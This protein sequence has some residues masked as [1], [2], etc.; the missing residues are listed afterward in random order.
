MIEIVLDENADNT[1]LNA[2]RPVYTINDTTEKTWEEYRELAKNVIT[3]YGELP[4]IIIRNDTPLFSVNWFAVA[5]FVESCFTRNKLEC[6]VFKV[7]EK[8][9]AIQAYKPFIALTIG[10][11]YIIRLY[12]EELDNVYKEIAG[13]SYLGLNIKEDYLENKLYMELPN[14]NE[15]HRISSHTTEEALTAVAILKSVAL[16]QKPAHIRAEILKAEKSPFPDIDRA[17]AKAVSY[18]RPWIN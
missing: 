4:I 13:L 1:F 2:E 14:G 6:V 7:K 9:A 5:L 18:V 10:L 11:K 12:Q 3:M 8:A 16:T 15:E 17:I